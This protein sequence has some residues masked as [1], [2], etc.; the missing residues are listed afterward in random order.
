MVRIVTNKGVTRVT[1]EYDAWG[2]ITN[3]TY[4]NKTLAD[5]NP[6]RYRG[7]YYDRETGLYYL[8]S[9]YYN[10][11]WGRFINADALVATGQGLL[12]N[13][14]FA[15][16]RN[17]PVSRKDAS[18]MDDV[19]VAHADDIDTPLNDLGY[20]PSGGY[21]N[22][23]N[24]IDAGY[25][26][27]VDFSMASNSSLTTGGIYGNGY[28]AYGVYSNPA[29]SGYG[30]TSTT[31]ACFI[32]GTLVQSEDGSKAIEDI[33]VGDK[34]WAWD[35]ETGDVA[36]KEVVETYINK[37]DELIHIFVNGEEIITTPTHPFYS[38]VRGW[39]DA[40]KLRA[41]DI[42]VLV[43]GEYVVVE[44][45]Q[46]EILETPIAVYNFQ[47]KDYHTY[48]VSQIGVCVNNKCSGSY[49]IHFL[50]GN[51]YVGKGNPGR[52]H[53]SAKF[54]SMLHKDSVVSMQWEYAPDTETAFV[55]EYFKMA[56][57]GVKNQNTYNLIWSPGRKI[58][59]QQWK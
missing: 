14:M 41:G 18:G 26:Y 59:I 36:L 54:Q 58:F 15:Y 49:E 38:P 32:A 4:T 34:V 8:Q 3:M 52:M 1:Y 24:S 55:D 28:T 50:S 44:K 40:C 56:V 51:N 9:R 25:H 27:G 47:V 7:Y 17:N 48:Y 16:C 35:E 29:G 33:S 30:S 19:C 6:L 13:N 42:L 20:T 57:R 37:T 31:I 23:Y 45:T 10:P 46:H 21:A 39:T 5:A 43:N 2:N 11:Q 12:G 53:A 22:A